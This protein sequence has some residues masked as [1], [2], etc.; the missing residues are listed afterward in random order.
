MAL[1]RTARAV[2][3]LTGHRRGDWPYCGIV[4]VR[5]SGELETVHEGVAAPVRGAKQRG[6]HT[7]GMREP[8]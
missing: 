5:L 6:Y 7:T 1:R 2:A 4:A 8:R 3:K